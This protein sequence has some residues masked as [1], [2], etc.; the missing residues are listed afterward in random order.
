MTDTNDQN[1]GGTLIDFASRTGRT[2]FTLTP[3]PPTDDPLGAVIPPPT[4]PADTL[5]DH[6]P[7]P[8]RSPMDIVDS[9]PSQAL[10]PAT[11]TA[12]PEPGLVPATFQNPDAPAPDQVGP[13]LGALS[14]AAILA[15]AVAAMRG[16]ATVLQDRRQRRLERAEEAKP[17]REAAQK[18]RLAMAQARYG[19]QAAA[20]KHSSAMQGIGAKA[21][22]Q[23]AKQNGKV[24]SSWEFGRKATGNRSGS[25]SGSKNSSGTGTG[26]GR[27]G[28]PGAG[29]GNTESK[30]SGSGGSGKS[31]G[32]GRGSTG[33]GTDSKGG[34]LRLG[35]GQGNRS[36]RK[37]KGSSA[38]GGA[39][40][41][42]GA[43]DSGSGRGKGR[44]QK[45]GGTGGGNRPGN[46]AGGRGRGKLPQT[47][48]AAQQR[49]KRR[50]KD[51]DPQVDGAATNG[52]SGSQQDTSGPVGKGSKAL[53]KGLTKRWR[54]KKSRSNG[55]GTGRTGLWEAFKQD[56]SQTAEDRWTMRRTK[57]GVPPLWKTD[58]KR[59]K[60][61]Q[62]DGPS[63]RGAN[64]GGGEGTS[65]GGMRDR[66]TR[67]RD[68]ARNTWQGSTRG[69]GDSGFTATAGPGTGS[70]GTQQPGGR[71]QRRSPYE[72]VGHAQP[73]DEFKVWRAD[74]PAPKGEDTAQEALTS[75][76][77][78]LVAA[79]EQHTKRP[80]TRRPRPM[81]PAPQTR[82]SKE[83]STMAK[84]IG[85][86]VGGGEEMAAEHRTE[87]SLDS[88]LDM[89]SGLTDDAFKTH[90]QAGR[91]AK[92]AITLRDTCSAFAEELKAKHNLIG[93]LFNGALVMFQESM[94]LLARMS[95]ELEAAALEAAEK[96][97]IA[98]TEMNDAYRPITQAAADANLP[99]PSA[100]IH[101]RA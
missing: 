10:D 101:N 28:K 80:G 11:I 41:G 89:L 75:G 70:R 13:R 3:T 87:V 25:G 56:T 82:T 57:Q 8:R 4:T 49:N 17:L 19:E 76:T 66:W 55:G 77:K 72:N 16:T 39:G 94:G 20:A 60:K 52:K 93:R 86:I 81:P 92:K 68:R 6:G 31:L 36:K 14:L 45:N 59:T 33:S 23:R 24:P 69:T 35:G 100:P 44:T 2:G 83:P 7:A 63:Q 34:K 65:H 43:K 22:Q 62:Q 73:A 9:L 96:C 26:P 30:T 1:P 91:L 88:A 97:E 64:P 5:V 47:L 85:K 95:E 27:G 50:K 98:D 67:A 32:G 53:P 51:R 29:K 71:G 46:G 58:K 15:V 48:K 12:T 61:K 78:A 21:A 74:K 37:D 99:A 79:P 84:A 40:S 54:F 90:D 38:G 42:S 18:N